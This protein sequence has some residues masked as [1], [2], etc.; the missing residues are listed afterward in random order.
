MLR[1]FNCGVGGILVVDKV[2]EV[3]FL[4]I[5]KVDNPSVIGEVIKSTGLYNKT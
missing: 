1:T 4:N 3:E 5:L 2:N